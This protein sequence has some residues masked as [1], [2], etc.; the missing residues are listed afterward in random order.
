MLFIDLLTQHN[1]I[2]GEK[3]LLKALL[4][5]RATVHFTLVDFYERCLLCKDV[6]YDAIQQVMH[7]LVVPFRRYR[8]KEFC[9][10]I[11]ILNGYTLWINK[12]V[13]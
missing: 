8:Q 2:F 7:G 3:K 12:S 4:G 6:H 10:L 5:S 1:E 9:S 13:D 11:F